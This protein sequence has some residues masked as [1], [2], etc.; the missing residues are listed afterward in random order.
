MLPRSASPSPLTGCGVESGRS[1]TASVDSECPWTPDESVTTT[2]RIAYQKIPNADLVVKDLGLLE[3][4]MPKA[5][6]KW[7]N[8]A[9]GGDVVQAYGANSVDIGLMGSSPRPRRCRSR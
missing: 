8:F 1:A 2:A 4:C 5:K 3:A 7:S 9:S 6:I